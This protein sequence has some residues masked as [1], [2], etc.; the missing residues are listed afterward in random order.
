MTPLEQEVLAE[1]GMDFWSALALPKILSYKL[2]RPSS[3][4]LGLKYALYFVHRGPEAL[5]ACNSQGEGPQC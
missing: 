1:A 2:P 3:A 5:H 4:E